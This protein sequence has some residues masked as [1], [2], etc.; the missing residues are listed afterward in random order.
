[1]SDTFTALSSA[2]SGY[3]VPLSIFGLVYVTLAPV[4]PKKSIRAEEYKQYR[5][6]LLPPYSPIGS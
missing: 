6:E 3:F 1:M 5:Q 2:K 4:K